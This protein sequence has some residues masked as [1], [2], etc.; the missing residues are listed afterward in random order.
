MALKRLA[1]LGILFGIAVDHPRDGAG[2]V[3]GEREE[4]LE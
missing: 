3:P 4:L 1:E 2:S